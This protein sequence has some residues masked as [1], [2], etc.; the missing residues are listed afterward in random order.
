M[1]TAE[2]CRL[3]AR[4]NRWQNRS[5]MSA[6]DSLSHEARWRDRSASFGSIAATL[7]HLLLDDTLWMARFSGDEKPEAHLDPALSSPIGW[8]EYKAMRIERDE[9]L[10]NWLGRLSS[11]DLE[12]DL[13]WYPGGFETR[14]SKPKTLCMIHL[15]NHQ[16]HHRG[17]VHAMLRA[18]GI[19]PPVTDLPMLSFEDF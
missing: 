15:F 10:V 8:D 16:T 6:G 13:S 19:K 4:Y 17:Q 11:S 12:G 2:Y 14:V 3:M 9:A 18:A 1:I 7:N 5:F